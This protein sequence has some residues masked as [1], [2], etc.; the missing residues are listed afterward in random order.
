MKY[1]RDNKEHRALVLSLRNALTSIL[2]GTIRVRGTLQSQLYFSQGEI[3][4]DGSALVIELRATLLMP[5]LWL[6]V[7]RRQGH[8]CPLSALVKF[9]QMALCGLEPKEK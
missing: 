1:L 2:M 7:G 3:V 4:V 6:N 5:A 9:E 8:T